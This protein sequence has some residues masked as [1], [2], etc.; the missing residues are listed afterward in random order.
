MNWTWMNHDQQ[1]GAT[2]GLGRLASTALLL[3]LVAACSDSGGRANTDGGSG[4][5]PAGPPLAVDF[6]LRR[7]IHVGNTFVNDVHGVDLEGDGLVDLVEANFFDEAVSIGLGNADGSFTTL[8]SYT[9]IGLPFKVTTGDFDGDG[10]EDIA[11]I[12]GDYVGRPSL[13]SRFSCRAP[14]MVSSGH[15]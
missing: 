13:A 12:C 2:R 7:D 15:S 10:R 6:A 1:H 3:S 14:M 9:T 4:G 11:A 5:P 8:G